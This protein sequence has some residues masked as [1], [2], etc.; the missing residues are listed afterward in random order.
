MSISFSL[1]YLYTYTQFTEQTFT[2]MYASTYNLIHTYTPWLDQGGANTCELSVSSKCILDHFKSHNTH[3]YQ[4]IV[5]GKL[6]GVAALDTSFHFDFFHGNFK[7][8]PKVDITL[9]ELPNTHH[10]VRKLIYS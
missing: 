2:Y 6:S 10:P 1:I 7:H 9:N 8:A 5:V 3:L 4:L